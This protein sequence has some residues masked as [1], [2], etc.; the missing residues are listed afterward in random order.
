MVSFTDDENTDKPETVEVECKIVDLSTDDFNI[1]FENAPLFS[2]RSDIEVQARQVTEVE[3]V[4]TALD[5]T[6]SI[7]NPG[8]WVVTNP[9]GEKY[10]VKE[11]IFANG[12]NKKDGSPGVFIPVGVPTKVVE[13]SESV[14]FVASWG[15][16]QGVRAGGV[17][18]ERQ[19]DTKERYG[20]EKQA[21]AD[22]Y[23]RMHDE[24]KDIP[25]WSS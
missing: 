13:V 15:S 14:V 5:G 12:Y 2:K 18:V 1:L 19:D 6:E 7:A 9:G 22:T 25:V 16:D 20:I 23:E 24:E 11:D 10:S 3:E 21:F 4:V 17:V 8:D